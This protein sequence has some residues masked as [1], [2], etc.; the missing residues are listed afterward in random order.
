MRFLTSNRANLKSLTA[1]L[2]LRMMLQM[3]QMR[4]VE[5]LDAL[6]KNLNFL[7]M[8][9]TINRLQ[10]NATRSVYK[11]LYRHD[12]AIDIEKKAIERVKTINSSTLTHDAIC[13]SDNTKKMQTSKDR[14]I[15]ITRASNIS[16]RDL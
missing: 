9:D 8:R 13:A 3:R 12:D 14:L 2:Q 4:D 11:E 6:I 10:K 16:R 5:R 15:N 1:M 7:A